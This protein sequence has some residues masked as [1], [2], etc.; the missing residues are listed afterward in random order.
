MPRILQIAGL[1]ISAAMDPEAVSKDND[2]CCVLSDDSDW[3]R[4][5]GK[6]WKTCVK[7]SGNCKPP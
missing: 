7:I 2:L 4:K 5:V 6:W 3:D 1:G